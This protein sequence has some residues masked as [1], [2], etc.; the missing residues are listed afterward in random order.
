MEENE[1]QGGLPIPRL[2]YNSDT[3]TPMTNCIHCD[4]ELARG[5]RFYLI[6]KVF[7]KY[8]SLDT[9]EVLFEY[10]ICSECYE[11]M[12]SSLSI[13]SMMNLSEYMMKNTDFEAMQQRIAKHP[14]HPEEWVSNCMIKGTHKSE[15]DEYQIGACFKGG[16]LVMDFM[17]PFIVGG[18]AMEEMNAILSKETK[19]EMD[20][21]MNDHFG[22]PPELRKD[23]ILF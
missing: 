13:E 8:P 15:M 18:A 1:E 10:A 4:Y 19:D 23:L 21:F 3:K 2:F 17:P 5:D 6:E 14:E 12:K 11:K 22:I 9:T 7:K 16:Q 20:G